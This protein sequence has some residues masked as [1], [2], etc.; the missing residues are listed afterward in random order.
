MLAFLVTYSSIPEKITIGTQKVADLGWG[1]SI[2]ADEFE[3]GKYTY[4]VKLFNLIPIKTVS[5]CATPERYLIPSGE[6][7]GVKM[8]TKGVLVVGIGDVFAEDGKKY[9]PAK[10]AGVAVGDIIVGVNGEEI[11]ST[12][13]FSKKVNEADG[14]I[15]LS[16]KREEKNYEI[17]VSAI[18]MPETN[19][20][21]V[22]LWVRDSAAGIG[23]LTFY[24]PE[25][26]TFAALGHAICDSDTKEIMELS[27]G[28]INFCS[29]KG[30][31]KGKSGSPGELLGSFQ[32]AAV[33]K[34]SKNSSLGIFGNLLKTPDKE[35][36]AVASKYD[37]RCGSAEIL[38][39]VSGD[40]VK[41]YEIEITKISKS[42]KVSN[43]SFTI[44]ITDKELLEKTGGIVQGMS[45]SPILQNGMI[46]GAVTHV[47]VNDPTRGYGIFIENMLAEAEKVK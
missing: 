14:K 38:C 29:I 13:Q 10:K 15:N 44:R 32:N 19:S 30:V 8:Y 28:S 24:D 17:P 39:D 11:S 7:I 40:G 43:K 12:A 21:K 27:K 22:G 6:A 9:Q 1:M 33:G 47:F 35:P 46:V 3:N 2:E 16:V 45:G 18:Y 5:V 23:T 42:Q 26:K 41:S 20:Y 25:N 36:V 37:I 31:K 34:I 4:P